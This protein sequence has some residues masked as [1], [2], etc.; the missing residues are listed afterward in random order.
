MPSSWRLARRGP[1]PL[2][3]LASGICRSRVR[4]SRRAP[5]CY[6]L[7]DCR[8][9]LHDFYEVEPWPKAVRPFFQV[10]HPSRDLRLPAGPG[11]L[12]ATVAF[13]E[14]SEGTGCPGYK[15]L[16]RFGD[17]EDIDRILVLVDESVAFVET[18]RR[19]AL[20]DI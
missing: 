20:E 2:R 1:S 15:L 7:T 19:A 8:A 13:G 3:W 5:I 10:G 18:S 6:S 14:R 16:V 12:A 9:L 4:S 17:E 11:S